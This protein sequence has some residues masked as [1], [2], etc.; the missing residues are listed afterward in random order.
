M[1]QRYFASL[2]ANAFKAIRREWKTNWYTLHYRAAVMRYARIEDE[3]PVCADR[4]EE[5]RKKKTDGRRAER[6]RQD[7]YQGAIVSRGSVSAIRQRE[8]VQLSK[9]AAIFNGERERR[10]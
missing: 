8:F 1:K 7:R 6:C 4:R 10:A 5:D 3:T 9:P 2:A